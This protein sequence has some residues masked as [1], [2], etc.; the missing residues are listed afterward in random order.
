ME[1]WR[2]RELEDWRKGGTRMIGGEEDWE[3]W[4]NGLGIG[5]GTKE[6]SVFLKVHIPDKQ[7]NLCENI[8]SRIMKK[9]SM[10]LL[11]EITNT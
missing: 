8:I 5:T 1:A 6:Q 9:A 2:R 4:R 11:Q 3:D 10:L 7:N